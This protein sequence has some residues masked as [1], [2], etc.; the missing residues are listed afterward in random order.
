[1]ALLLFYGEEGWRGRH[2]LA[3]YFLV[4]RKRKESDCKLLAALL[5]SLTQ[6]TLDSSINFVGTCP[7]L[8]HCQNLHDGPVP[9]YPSGPISKTQK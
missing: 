5:P 3:P 2:C 9:G 6:L 1:M 4:L 7:S 8:R